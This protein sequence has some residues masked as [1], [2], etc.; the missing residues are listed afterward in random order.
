MKIVLLWESPKGC[1]L[2]TQMILDIDI[3]RDGLYF[4][5]CIYYIYINYSILFRC[6][7]T[8]LDSLGHFILNAILCE[9]L[10]IQHS[11]T[12]KADATA[13]ALLSDMVA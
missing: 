11:A 9:I 8:S 4:I 10:F 5:L 2:T 7:T 6:E 12:G 1:S 13:R 3:V